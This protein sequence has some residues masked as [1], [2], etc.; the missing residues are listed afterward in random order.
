[1]LT[2]RY[3]ILILAPFY[4]EFVKGIVDAIAEHASEISIIVNHNRLAEVSRYVPIGGY[5]SHVRGYTANRLI[6]QSNKPDNVNV[7]LLSMTYLVPDGKNS[8]L[9]DVL[10]RKTDQFIQERGL[11]FDIIQGHFTWPCGYAAVKLA[12][13]YEVPSALIIHENRDWLH[14]MVNSPYMRFRWTWENADA[15]VRVNK[16]DIPVLMQYSKEVVHAPGGFNPKIF[17]PIERGV[18]RNAVGLPSGPKVI[19]GLGYL[20]RRKGFQFLVQAVHDLV[21]TNPDLICVI[22]G[23]GPARHDLEGMARRLG[24]SGNIRFV[25]FIARDKL[26]YYYNA[27][28]L[29]VLPSLSEGNPTVMFEALACG[30]PFIGTPV[31]GVPEV[32]DS[33]DYGILA[34]IGDPEDLAAKIQEGLSKEWDRQKIL[35]EAQRYSWENTVGPIVDLHL[36]LIA[37]KH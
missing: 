2:S 27:A 8:R 15:L 35:A 14:R 29:F 9:G 13:K 20:T 28:D 4:R 24:L 37:P 32:I 6:D 16:L 10:F 31:G 7:N 18:A 23:M 5:F 1:M 22:G 12:R 25:D 26:N 34:R 17:F 33:D 11:K 30:V 19:F 21:E 3:S 36:R